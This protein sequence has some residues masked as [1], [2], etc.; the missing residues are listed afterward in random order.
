MVLSL[1]EARKKAPR[2]NS[3]ASSVLKSATTVAAFSPR[4]LPA[5][6][7]LRARAAT[8]V[9]LSH[10]IACGE[11]TDP[12]EDPFEDSFEDPFAIPFSEG[13]VVLKKGILGKA[14]VAI[15]PPQIVPRKIL[16]TLILHNNE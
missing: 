3:L 12:F 16:P 2:R 11:V 5:R 6:S 8:S 13:S 9:R 10:G 14:V 7:V 4:I 1:N 15:K